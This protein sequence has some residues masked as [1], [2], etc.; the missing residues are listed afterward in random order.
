[1]L[2]RWHTFGLRTR[3]RAFGSVSCG[4]CG[5][6]CVPVRAGP[7]FRVR[8]TAHGTGAYAAGTEDKRHSTTKAQRCGVNTLWGTDGTW[9]NGPTEC[10]Y[11]GPRSPRAAWVRIT[12]GAP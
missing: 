11:Q 3:T 6:A 7:C 2:M 12:K 1:M 10:V 8:P 4:L 9:D 5:F